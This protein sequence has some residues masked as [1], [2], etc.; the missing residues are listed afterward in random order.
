MKRSSS[1]RRLLLGGFSVGTLATSAAVAAE[2]RITPESYYSNDYFIGGAGYYHAPFKAF[3]AR[4]YNDY[5]PA[6]KMYFH[7]GTWSPTPHRSI[8]NVSA[9]TLEAAR[10][11][12]STRT[13]L[14]RTQYVPRAGFGSTSSSH[15]IPS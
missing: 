10:L 5:D 9:P 15:F 7:G 12:E 3:F 14:A 1:V 4:P 11:A 6:R 8:V 13:D 2:A